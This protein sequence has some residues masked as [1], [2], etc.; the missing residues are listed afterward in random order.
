MSHRNQLLIGLLAAAV[1]FCSVGFAEEKGKILAKVDKFEISQSELD[2]RLESLPPQLQARFQSN[3]AQFL[4]ELINQKLLLSEASKQKI[5]Q[6]EKL[7][8]VLE[9]LKSELMVQRLVEKEILEKV[10]V[11][12][13]EAEQYYNANKQLFMKPEQV[14]AFHILVSDEAQAKKVRERLIKGEDFEKVAKETS[15][16][17][18]SPRGGDLGFVSKGQ[19]VPEFETAAF[20][21]KIGEISAPVKTQFGYHVIKVT[22]S[23]PAQQMQY[24]EIKENVKLQL[25]Q[26]RQ[27]TLLVE[28]IETLKKKFT[29]KIYENEKS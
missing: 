1:G 12:D 14:H 11:S 22:E 18:S 17:P 16:G 29:V 9:Q 8:S 24:D 27:R 20:A 7:I 19:L 23:T 6:D 4:N 21:L 25:Q 28:F 3:K 10:N 5:D 13:Q 15:V 26:E 2:Q